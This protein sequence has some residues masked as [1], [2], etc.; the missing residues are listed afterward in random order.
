MFALS[1]QLGA[2]RLEYWEKRR[3]NASPR[4]LESNRGRESIGS[5]NTR[6]REPKAHASAPSWMV[7]ARRLSDTGRQIDRSSRGRSRD[8]N[9]DRIRRSFH[10]KHVLPIFWRVLYF[11][12][13][14]YTNL[15]IT[16]PWQWA[17]TRKTDYCATFV[18]R[19]VFCH[20]VFQVAW[21]SAT[22]DVC[23]AFSGQHLR[24]LVLRRR[25]WGRGY[26]TRIC[27]ANAQLPKIC[28]IIDTATVT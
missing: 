18:E 5:I 7:P 4:R 2:N 26:T 28:S 19:C 16:I 13:R 21:V 25:R 8:P 23:R 9:N 20:P 3:K 24:R 22:D 11:C 27:S 14:A 15:S 6:G 1:L 12:R 10:A 17:L